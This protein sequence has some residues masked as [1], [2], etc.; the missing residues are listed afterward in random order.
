[1]GGEYITLHLP[2]NVVTAT[3]CNESL[4]GYRKKERKREASLRN[5]IQRNCEEGGRELTWTEPRGKGHDKNRYRET[6]A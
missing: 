6:V 3:G 4:S 5:S 2:E 1:M